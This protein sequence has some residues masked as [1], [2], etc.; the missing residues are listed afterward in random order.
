TIQNKLLFAQTGKTAAELII[1]RADGNKPNMGL[2]TFEGS[3]V[4]K[5]DIDTAKNYLAENE[6][7][8]LNR[9]VN[10]F[11]DF[12]EDR[13]KKRSEIT[14]SE[15]IKQTEEFLTVYDRDNLDNAGSKAHQQMLAHTRK[16]FDIFEHNR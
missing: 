9:L 12:A 4:R 16:Q 5:R 8:G 15:W 11:L 6:V 10:M 2:T 1:E 14:L 13:A 7:D 3:V